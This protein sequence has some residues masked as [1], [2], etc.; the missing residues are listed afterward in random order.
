M[1]NLPSGY[2]GLVCCLLAISGS[3]YLHHLLSYN[4]KGS[5]T[6]RPR[7][8]RPQAARTLQVHVFELGSKKFEMNEFMKWKPWAARFSD[9]LAFILLSNKSCTNLELHEFFHSPKK[10]A[11]QGLTVVCLSCM[12]GRLP[13]SFVCNSND[14]QFIRWKKKMQH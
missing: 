4:T 10:R 1:S 8:T 2:E 9:N 7:D 11:S 3:T 12:V 5:P 13:Y 14:N 6:V